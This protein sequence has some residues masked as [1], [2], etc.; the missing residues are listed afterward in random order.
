MVT[1]LMSRKAPLAIAFLVCIL[2]IPVFA[3]AQSWLDPWENRRPVEISNPCGADLENYQV[4]IQ[5][6]NSFDFTAALFNGSDIR[7]TSDDGATII[8]SWVEAWDPIGETGVVWVKV[9]LLPVSG[10]TVYLYYGNPSPPGPTIEEVPPVGPWERQTTNIVP[11]DDPGGGEALLGENMVYDDVTGHYWLV[12]DAYRSG[13]W[14]GLVYSDTPDDPTSWYWHGQVVANA[15]APHILEYDGL[16]Y[17]FYADRTIGPPYP[18]SVDTSS[19]IGGPYARAATVLT[20]TESWEAYRVDEPYVFQRNDGKWILMYMGDIG[21]ATEQVGYAEAD[22]ILGPY[23]KFPGNPCIPFGPPGSFDAGT[24]ADPWV[25]EFHDT[26]YIGYTVSPTSSSPWQTAIA[27]T[28]DWVNFNK[29]GIILSLGGPG[30]WDERNAFRGAVTR[31]GDT[32]YFPYTGRRTSGSYIMGMATQPAYMEVPTN[33]P[34]QVFNFIDNFDN[35][36]SNWV[37][38][39]SGSAAGAS[40]EIMSGVLEVTAVPDNYV[41]MRANTA[42]GTGTL[43]ETYASHPDAGLSPGT[44]EGNAAGEV[45]Y[46]PSDLSWNNVMRLVDWPDLSN[47]VIQASSGGTNSGYVVTDVPF[48]TEWHMYRLFRDG[49]SIRFQVDDNPYSSLGPPYVPTIDMFPWLMSY[50]RLPATQSR[51]D[52]DWLRVRNFCGADAVAAVGAEEQAGGGLSG[53]VTADMEGLHGVYIDLYDGDDNLYLRAI[54]DE[55]GYYSFGS[56][57]PGDYTVAAQMPMGFA[58]VSSQSVPFTMGVGDVGVDFELVEA[59]SGSV[60]DYWWWLQQFTAI[61]DGTPLFLGITMEDANNYCEKIFNGYYGRDDGYEIQIEG[62]TFMDDPPRPLN[63]DDL[64]HIFIDPHDGTTASKNRRHML[65]VMLNVAAERLSQLA[66]VS[67][68]GATASQGIY[69]YANRYLTGDP[70]DWTIWYN[71]SKISQSIIIPA[72]QVLLTT[73]NIMYGGYGNVAQPATI[74]CPSETVN[75]TTCG[76]SEVCVDLVIENYGMVTVDG[77]TWADN[78][79]CFTP[80]A[81]SLFTFHVVATSAEPAYEPAT[82]DI[83][84]DVDFVDPPAITCPTS[85]IEIFN[86]TAGEVCQ[87][88][89]IADYDEVNVSYGTWASNEL[90]FD[91]DTAGT[92]NIDVQAINSCDTAD[93]TVV[94]N[95]ELGSPVILTCPEDTANVIIC[96]PGEICLDLP[97][98]NWDFVVADFGGWSDNQ[99]CFTAYESGL[100][101][102]VVAAGNECDT[103]ECGVFVDVEIGPE[104]AITCPADTIDVLSGAGTVCVDLPIT[105]ATSVDAG[106]AVWSDNSLCFD[107]TASGVYEFTVIG[108]NLCDADTCDIYVNVDVVS[109][110]SLHGYVAGDAMPLEGVYVELLDDFG[111]PYMMTTTDEAGYYHFDEIPNGD[112]IVDLQMPLGFSPIT[113]ATVPLTLAAPD[114]EVDFELTNSASGSVTDYWWWVSQLTAIRNGTPLF[115]G[116]TLDDVNNYCDAIFDHFY[117]RDDGYAIQIEEVTYMGAPAEALDFDD[118]VHIYLDPH[119][120]TNASKARRHILTILLNVAAERLSQM[121]AVSVDGATASQAIAYFADWYQNGNPEDWQLWYYASM[122]HQSIPIPAGVIPLSTPNIMYRPEGGDDMVR[123]DQWALYQ[124]CPNPFNPVT[125]IKFSLPIASDVRLDIYNVMGQNIATLVNSRLDAGIHT[126]EWNATNMATGVYFYRLKAGAFSETKKMILL[127]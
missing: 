106:A 48:D 58:P 97:V 90:C 1:Y 46:K 14:V 50:T 123:P 31:F 126:Y 24:V 38:T 42:V 127:K 51:Y 64:V 118:L 70:E 81:D 82:C 34:A 33:D 63:F 7:V 80:D 65:T 114:V 3:N 113:P 27:T 13:Q 94:F 41:Q 89:P 16:W 121:A 28:T 91:A 79:L 102:I 26:Y 98:D 96:E 86:C 22:N 87:S 59:A 9:P 109:I 19:N 88:L 110:S 112:Y 8:P 116:I 11:I 21:S 83:S 37:V 5:L 54:T 61:N 84:I 17:I 85:P 75:V 122:V 4:A 60:T 119:D 101:Y 55:N 10:L 40:A 20:V 6:D 124:N 72:G 78:Q 108:E 120:G 57:P 52:V 25:V 117:S 76:M 104:V 29:L 67:E 71:L 95:V 49:D 36:L 47:Y 93:C 69:Y 100:Y 39:Y 77:A 12:F 45:G 15:N 53:Q 62:V 56:L 74:A 2:L 92:Y 125:E 18:I 66:V 23:T 44:V 105:G 73:A 111:D 35:D 68:D 32:Y 107:V 115:L 30:D 99:L 43:L 103:V